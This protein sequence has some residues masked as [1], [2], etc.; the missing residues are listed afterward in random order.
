MH[1]DS[2]EA[3]NFN[4]PQELESQNS[5]H[6]M[7]TVAEAGRDKI[8]FKESVDVSCNLIGR[9]FPEEEHIL[10]SKDISTVNKKFIQL[11]LMF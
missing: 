7:R 3:P 1:T 8:L 11:L 2:S 9:D 6:K 10:S 5:P 4:L